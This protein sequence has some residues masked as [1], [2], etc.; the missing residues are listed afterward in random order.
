MFEI[1]KT[2]FGEFLAERRKERGYT[3]KALAE[4]L[5]VSDKA[6]SKWERGLSLPDV[7]LLI[8]LAELLDVTVA[9]LLEGR[10]LDAGTELGAELVDALV[11]K[12]ITLSGDSPEKEKEKQRRAVLIFGGCAAAALAQLLIAG[13]LGYDIWGF[14]G[15]LFTL[16]LLSFIFGIYFWFFAK[17]QLPAY[18]DENKINAY[19]DGIFRMNL[20]GVSFN[21]SNWPHIVGVGRIW[22]LASMAG[23]PLIFLLLSAFVPRLL[24]TNAVWAALLILYLGGLFIP[25]FI[26]GKKYE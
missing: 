2:A 4:R 25:M 9:E 19:S 5:F 3:Q 1:D 10:S 26:V 21:N 23:L 7:S 18:Y 8:P 15:T 13:K 6:V 24:N 12:A 20:P 22:T 17:E 11:K 16:V 14:G